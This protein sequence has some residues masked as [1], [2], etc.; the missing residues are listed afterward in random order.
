MT[1]LEILKNSIENNSVSDEIIIFEYLDTDFVCNQYIQ[2]ISEI[3]NMD[4]EYIE[5]IDRFLHPDI[6]DIYNNESFLYVYRI[7]TLS[8]INENI[9]SR[10]NIVIISNKIE[11]SVKDIYYKYI[12]EIPRLEN[13]QIK[14]YVYSIEPEI[15]Q[16]KLNNLLESCKYNIYRIDN[17]LHKI[18]M[19]SNL[20]KP[21]VFDEFISE[22][23][24][25]D[26]SKYSVFDFT[27]AILKKDKEKLITIYKDKNNVDI[28]PIGVVTILVNSFRDV[29][30]LQF[31]PRLTPE[32][33]GIQKN[34]F[35]AIKYN[36]GYYTNKE[37]IDIFTFLCSLDLKVKNGYVSTDMLIDYIIINVLKYNE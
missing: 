35:W 15:S 28:E 27:N 37:L 22:N 6:F 19:F 3:K 10:Q 7:D 31:D 16:D 11:K 29:I 32:T 34:K 30:R 8:E 18:N 24:F 36:C 2:K 4:V 33:S 26:L 12:Y 9:F 1:N 17:E 25:S 20:E 14:D 13:W 5:D 21:Y 23:V